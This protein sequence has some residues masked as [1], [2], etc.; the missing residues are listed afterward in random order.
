MS[1]ARAL[2]KNS[3]IIILD[4]A[5]GDFF[6]EFF[7]KKIWLLITTPQICISLRR[8]RDR[9]ENPGHNCL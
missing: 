2:V 7:L 4:E 9:P 5:T 8:L 6:S 1:L 3:K